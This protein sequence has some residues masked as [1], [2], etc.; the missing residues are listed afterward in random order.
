MPKKNQVSRH[1]VISVSR[2]QE[3][4]FQNENAAVTEKFPESN[5]KASN[6]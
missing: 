6:R 3:K 4:A 1:N 5:G 2:V